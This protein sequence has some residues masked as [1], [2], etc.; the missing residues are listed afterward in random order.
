MKLRHA[1]LCQDAHF[2]EATGAVQASGIADTLQFESFPT[3]ARVTAVLGLEETY[4]PGR[5]SLVTALLSDPRRYPLGEYQG[6]VAVRS[7]GPRRRQ[8]RAHHIFD[9]EFNATEPGEYS[10][11]LRINHALVKIIHFD[12]ERVPA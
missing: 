4:E 3:T 12:I 6:T 2:D 9:L 7:S 1:F 8:W 11:R 10:L 5:N